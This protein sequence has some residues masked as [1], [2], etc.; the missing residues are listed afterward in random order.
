MIAK[1]ICRLMV[2]GLIGVAL[3]PGGL[4]KPATGQDVYGEP[5]Q[6]LGVSEVLGIGYPFVTGTPRGQQEDIM[7]IPSL[8]PWVTI[9]ANLDLSYRST[10]FDE[11]DHDTT[12]FLGDSRLEFWIPPWDEGLAWGPY[13][14]MAGITSNRDRA[15]ENAWLAGPGVGFHAFLFSHPA[16]SNPDS[17]ANKIFGPLR[18]FAERNRLYF[19]HEEN[20]WRP[21]AQTRVGADYWRAINVNDTSEPLW[22]EIWSGLFWQSANEFDDDY[23]SVILGNAVRGGVRLPKAGVLS[24]LTPYVLLESSLTDN[25]EYFWENKLVGG[26]GLR[27]TPHIRRPTRDWLTRLVVYAEYLEVVDYYR[28]EGLSGTPD[29]DFRAGISLSIGE[30]YRDSN[31]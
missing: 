2:L 9:S 16:L 29:H 12:L 11:P 17:L 10:T 14:R 25:E 4:P 30:W 5:N 31:W 7:D 13:L 19:L 18:L 23:E 20:E 22:T 6:L 15:W 28:E 26:V 8:P 1:W 21:D 24:T 3:L 27:L